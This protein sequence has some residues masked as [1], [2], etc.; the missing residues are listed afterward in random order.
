MFNQAYENPEFAGRPQ[1]HVYIN[2]VARTLNKYAQQRET[3]GSSSDSFQL[4][5]F[6][7]IENF[8]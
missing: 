7:Q 6:F 1:P 4:R 5:F 8:S 3:S 2:G